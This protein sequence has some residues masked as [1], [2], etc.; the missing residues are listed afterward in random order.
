MPAFRVG[1]LL[2]F[3]TY[4]IGKKIA[5]AINLSSVEIEI[6][7][8]LAKGGGVSESWRLVPAG[9]SASGP[10]KQYHGLESQ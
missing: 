9:V 6:L 10:Q 2:E 4:L 1:Y 7:E 8:A 5:L 3:I